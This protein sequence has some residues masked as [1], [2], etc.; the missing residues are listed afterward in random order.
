MFGID[1]EDDSI[2]LT[3]GDKAEFSFYRPIMDVS[4]GKISNYIFKKGDK[5]TFIVKKKKGYAKLE[6]EIFRK[7]FIIEEETP[8]PLIHLEG[9]E[10]KWGEIKNKKT[11]Y[12]FD[13]VVNDENTPI[14]YNEDGATKLY[15][16]PEAGEREVNNE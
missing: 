16:Y 4:S 3:R 10:T 2:H 8:Y 5:V 9:K 7:D 13:I 12:W 1:C 11:V 6:D 14:G 15:L